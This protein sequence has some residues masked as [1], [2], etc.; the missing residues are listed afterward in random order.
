MDDLVIIRED[1]DS[2]SVRSANLPIVEKPTK[3]E[4]RLAALVERRR[5]QVETALASG[6]TPGLRR[7]RPFV[8][9]WADIASTAGLSIRQ[10]QRKAAGGEFDPASLSSVAAFLI[11]R[12][13]QAK[14]S[15]RR[16]ASP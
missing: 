2:S 1:A 6:R 16:K 8:Y 11:R 3:N 5:I 12:A 7:P 15:S 13:T 4:E 9:T 14:G 10:L